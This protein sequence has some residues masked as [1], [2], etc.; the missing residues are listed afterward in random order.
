MS[1]SNATTLFEH[2]PPAL[3]LFAARQASTAQLLF[4]SFWPVG[5]KKE[6][7]TNA[8]TI[9]L[10]VFSSRLFRRTAKFMLSI[11]FVH[12]CIFCHTFSCSGFVPYLRTFLLVWHC[13]PSWAAMIYT[14]KFAPLVPKEY[15]SFLIHG[16]AILLT[17]PAAHDTAHHSAGGR[18]A[19]PCQTHTW[20]TTK[21]LP[22]KGDCAPKSSCL[23]KEI[24]TPNQAPS[25]ESHTLPRLSSGS[26]PL[27]V[28]KKHS[29]KTLGVW[30][31]GRL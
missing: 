8:V 17:L 21:S 13:L 5:R 11:F 31:T 24:V 30:D 29:H 26:P 22:G 2:F 4:L 16:I 10:F 9:N 12:L 25:W 15:L 20:W 23:E 3:P 14:S 28:Q 19:L 7:T 18:W 1:K 6:Q 27:S